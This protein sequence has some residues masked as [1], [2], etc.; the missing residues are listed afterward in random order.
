MLASLSDR[1]WSLLALSSLAVVTSCAAAGPAPGFC[2]CTDA[3]SASSPASAP[4]AIPPA[5]LATILRER[6]ALARADV[7]RRKLQ[8]KDGAGCLA[9]L[10]AH[11]QLDPR[12]SQQSVDPQS[13][14]AWMRASCLFAAGRCDEGRKLATASYSASIGSSMGPEAVANAVDAMVMMSCQSKDASPR[15]QFLHATGELQAGAWQRKLAPADCQRAFD[16]AKAKRPATI[17]DDDTMVKS[18]DQGML[19]SVPTCFAKAGDCTAAWRTYEEL[20]RSKVPATAPKETLRSMFDSSIAAC[21]G[22]P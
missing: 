9:D 5:D 21:K 1:V 19:I 15:D 13:S 7:A 14:Y 12:P 17:A 3:S 16:T 8:T 11:D 4:I 2:P 10:D 20:W 18:A 22:K 6:E